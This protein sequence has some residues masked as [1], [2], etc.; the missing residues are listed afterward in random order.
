[1]EKFSALPPVSMLNMPSSWFC[2]KMS[3]RDSVFA[4]GSE[5][6][7]DAEND[8]NSECK[9]DL[10]SQIPGFPDLLNVVHAMYLR[11]PFII[12]PVVPF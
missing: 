1:M 11:T 2:W 10:S 6:A 7:E 8:D 5:T 4:P 12:R 3:L 9:K